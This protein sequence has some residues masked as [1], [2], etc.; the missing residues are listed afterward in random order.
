M[1]LKDYLLVDLQ[2]NDSLIDDTLH[3]ILGDIFL[4][5]L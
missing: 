3:R 5:I 1:D 2:C 4:K